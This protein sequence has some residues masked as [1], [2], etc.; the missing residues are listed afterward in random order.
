MRLRPHVTTHGSERPAG[1]TATG[2]LLLGAML[3]GLAGC[4][5][6]RVTLDAPVQWWHDL[7]GGT[8]AEHRPP[9]PGLG[10]PYPKVGTVPAR[11]ALP[12]MAARVGQTDRLAAEREQAER[13][14]TRTP[15]PPPGGATT[16]ALASEGASAAQGA[17][18]AAAASGAPGAAAGGA[19]PPASGSGTTPAARAPGRTAGTGAP[20]VAPAPGAPAADAGLR[21]SAA[22]DPTDAAPA[23]PG[24]AG[25]SVAS[26]TLAA[27]SA[28][29]PP[30]APPP[31][32]VP[33][34]PAGGPATPVQRATPQELAVLQGSAPAAGTPLVVAG[35]AARRRRPRSRRVR[36]TVPRRPRGR[37]PRSRRAN[38]CRG[39]RPR[40][41]SRGAARRCGSSRAPR[42][43]WPAR[44]GCCARSRRAA[45]LRRSR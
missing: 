18:P 23:A 14:A 30:P 42:R 5:N 35:Q 27:A 36:R 15:L 6:Q 28:P 1:G 33:K 31:A 32:T 7:E 29:A 45:A 40:S 34:N 11:P 8:I 16:Q 22:P 25:S 2:A 13:A 3:V 44:P 19:A 39:P 26:A 38:P 12:D 24:A 43:C 9:P 20:G 21:A 37:S 41:R 17:P 10:L 4:G